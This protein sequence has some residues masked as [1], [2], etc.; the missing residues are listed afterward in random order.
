MKAWFNGEFVEW[1]E[2]NVPILSHSFSRGSAIYEVL[3]IVM[4]DRGPA[5]FGLNEHLERFYKSA[6]LLYMNLPLG[7][8]EL[9]RACLACAGEN[10]VK[11]GGAKFYA[12]F[13][14]M[15]FG[16]VPQGN[17]IGIAIF[18]WDFDQLGTKQEDL[19]KPISVGISRYLKLHGSTTPIHAK[20]AGNYV[21][22]YLALR[23]VKARGYDD[24][25]LLDCAG[26]VAE[27]PTASACFVKDERLLLPP[28]D[29]VLKGVTRIAVEELAPQIGL[30]LEVRHI[31]P[32]ELKTMDEA[33]YSVS[34]KKIVPIKDI[35]GK[36]FRKE[37]PGPVTQKI[38]A[39][40]NDV[41]AGRNP[42]FIK[43]LTFI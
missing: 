22:G 3:D 12:Y 20:V 9:K 25:L 32:E 31:Y 41:Y 42:K 30:D 24:A 38:S 18:C 6:E 14:A 16:E 37:C 40:L 17:Q 34:L 21:N 33:F 23:D 4:T 11:R 1:G 29:N 15:E 28:F 8:E 19:S 13:S 10:N 27:A 35:E 39:Q 7:P 2:A 5:Y 26:R 43:W 36:A